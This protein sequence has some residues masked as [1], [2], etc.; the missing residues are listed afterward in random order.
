MGFICILH[1]ENNVLGCKQIK[2]EWMSGE[3]GPKKHYKI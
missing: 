1:M 3:K 2:A